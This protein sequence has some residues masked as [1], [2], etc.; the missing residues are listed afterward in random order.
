MTEAGKE[1]LRSPRGRG[2]EA[3]GL[4]NVAGNCRLGVART[5]YTELLFTTREINIWPPV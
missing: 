1:G 2:S 3:V 4:V 5:Y